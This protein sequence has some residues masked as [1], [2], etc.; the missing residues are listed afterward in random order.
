MAVVE[1]NRLN[2]LVGRC[3]ANSR[4]ALGGLVGI[5]GRAGNMV[6]ACYPECLSEESAYEAPQA[7]EPIQRPAIV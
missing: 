5:E 6:G 2:L 1:R 7:R 3:K 4:R